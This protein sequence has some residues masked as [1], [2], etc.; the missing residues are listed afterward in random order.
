MIVATNNKDKLREIK[1]ILSDFELYSLKDKNINI[2]VI[3]DN[4]TFL[5]NAEKKSLEIYEIAKEA[6]IA[7]DSGLCI[8][9]LGGFPGVLTNRFLGENKTDEE[10]N[11]YLIEKTNECNDRSAK[12]VCYIV[13]YNGKETIIGKG[14]LNGLIAKN[15]RGLNGFGFDEIFELENGKTLAELSGKEKNQISARR[16]ALENLRQKLMEER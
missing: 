7:D 4:D 14:I 11:N 16:M 1:E 10:R 15:R 6:V 9:A 3:E 5:E 2:K 8:N 13:Y 12:V